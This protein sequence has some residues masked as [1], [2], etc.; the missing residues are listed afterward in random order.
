MKN[1]K[2]AKNTM[3]IMRKLYLKEMLFM[4]EQYNA[5]LLLS[6]GA[7]VLTIAPTLVS[8]KSNEVQMKETIK[9]EVDAAL[10]N[11]AEVSE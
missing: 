11:M 1:G 8:T 6:I 3:P 5:T 4:K 9:K 2:Y 10:K 7:T